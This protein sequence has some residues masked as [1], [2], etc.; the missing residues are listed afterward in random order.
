[1]KKLLFVSVLV[2]TTLITGCSQKIIYQDRYIPQYIEFQYD[3]AKVESA[4]EVNTVSEWLGTGDTPLNTIDKHVLDSLA[5]KA[6]AKVIV[7]NNSCVASSLTLMN[8]ID[9]YNKNIQEVR[10]HEEI[11]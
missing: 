7:A 5:V 8:T 4:L 9:E 2:L 6:L 10:D 11:K 3:R 1:M